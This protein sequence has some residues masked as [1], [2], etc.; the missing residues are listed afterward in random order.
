MS[1]AFA[2]R[3]Q[4]E[5]SRQILIR[6]CVRDSYCCS[7]IYSVRL[8]AT[9][10]Y[11]NSLANTIIQKSR[12]GNNPDLV[13]ALDLVQA[14]VRTFNGKILDVTGGSCQFYGWSREEMVGNISHILLQTEFPKPLVE[15]EMELERNRRWAGELK[16]RRKDGSVVW[17]ASQWILHRK[18][19]GA[20]E[21][22][23]EVNH[24]ITAQ[25]HAERIGF[26]SRAH[27]QLA[28]DTAELGTWEVDCVAQTITMGRRAREIFGRRRSTESLQDWFQCIHPD[29]RAN[30]MARMDQPLG[31]GSK[32]II[33]CRVVQQDG[34]IRWIS[35]QETPV[36]DVSHGSRKIGV[37][38]DVTMQKESERVLRESE[39]RLRRLTEANVVGIVV[40]NRY[41]ILEANDYFLQMLGFDRDEL[42]A[43]NIDWPSITASDHASSA[44]KAMSHLL[45]SGT[46]S[47]VE[48]EYFH[49]NGSRV[50]V[51]V[52]SVLL[53]AAPEPVFLS[54]ILDLSDRKKL[55]EQFRQSQK[56]ESVGLLA[57]GI[58][59]DFNNLLTVITGY[60]EM[61]LR[62]LEA[63]NPLTDFVEQIAHAANRASALT[64][65]LLTFGR[66][67]TSRPT[68]V[69][70]N[71]MVREV[72]RMLSR[73]IS[74]DVDLELSLRAERAGIKVDP[75]QL[76]Q[77]IINL[78]VNARDAMPGGGKLL[79]ESRNF[80]VDERFSATHLAISPGDYVML[81][82][83]DTGTGM[84][85]EVQSHVFEPFFTTKEQG[86]GTGLGLS[87]VYGIVVQSGGTIWVYSEPGRGTT[88]KI[89]LPCV[90]AVD[91]PATP[92][93][94]VPAVAGNETILV[95]EDETGVRK[96]VQ[97]VL[98]RYGYNVLTAA[99]GREALD[100]AQSY[101]GPIHLLVTDVVMPEMG[102]TELAKEFVAVREGVPVLR[103]SGYN[104]RIER[105]AANLIP[106]L[107]KP[108]TPT[109][110]I[111]SIRTALHETVA[112]N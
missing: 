25:K 98:E 8:S 83:S 74:E 19:D 101:Q 81:S 88:F 49:K 57:G 51:M 41:Q 1:H 45:Q 85:P 40:A 54:F 110:L 5:F 89:L 62:K 20:A 99:N 53:E 33:E 65:Q 59:H 86:K 78:A 69:D 71:E 10:T 95:A 75:G 108:F 27:L 97:E 2:N 84:T 112:C 67:E 18:A 36:P 103:M 37:L 17:V 14:L 70:L 94:P 109:A 52:G 96:F 43:G 16:H 105:K 106:Y 6:N 26:Q 4:H 32:S 29:D 9:A 61:A 102:G 38:Q 58:A 35:A 48:K 46:C 64:R 24:D 72:E 73:L 21:F 7:D 82:V 91:K 12:T 104:D 23:T 13:E 34:S 42:L 55:E 100:R 68:T 47:A 15:I 92:L 111:Q 50:S 77:V 93:Q 60:S 3:L 39:T 44:H 66:R 28:L 31:L 22:I 56:L 63:Q 11:M 30:V 79:I 87:T 90:N 107:E 80:Y 76:D